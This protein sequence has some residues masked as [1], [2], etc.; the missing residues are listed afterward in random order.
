MRSPAKLL[1]S[2][3]LM[4]VVLGT[5]V[6]S[7]PPV[8]AAANPAV[9]AKR[10]AAVMEKI[11]DGLMVIQGAGEYPTLVQFRQDNNF[12]YLTGIDDTS[13]AI[14]VMDG[15][16]K[17]TLLFLPPFDAN[18]EKWFGHRMNPGKEAT[19][20]T[21]IT[22]SFSNKDFDGKIAELIGDSNRAV[23]I[24][25]SPME[26]GESERGVAAGVDKTELTTPWIKRISKQQAFANY[27]ESKKAEVKDLDPI[28]DD[29]R[30]IKGQEEIELVRE[31]SAIGSQGHIEA[32]KSVHAGMY[33]YEIAALAEYVFKR[34]G[35]IGPSYFPIAGSGPNSCALHYSLNNRKM[36]DGD[37]VVFDFA[38]DYG[39]Y[40]SDITR[41]FPVSGKFTDEQRKVYQVVLTAQKAG[42]AAVKP[43]A[44][45]A[46]VTKAARDVINAAG[47]GKYWAHGIGHY[48][49]M[50][51]HDVGSYD[52][53]FEPGVVLTV[54]PGIYIPEKELGV[55]I[56]D[57]VLVTK[58]GREV[59]SNA[60][61]EINDIEKLMS[62]GKAKK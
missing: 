37:I 53:P 56:E 24:S 12:Y 26:L 47:Y 19:E 58:E 57:V 42:I 1:C 2:I 15:K 46:D 21:G 49:G 39:Y 22:E 32:I 54:E 35:A 59:L 13:D 51:V 25:K 30:R 23:Y 34:S 10:R 62:A 17:R 44:T 5:I 7:K 29:M 11:G 28:L 33:E 14:L 20:R 9:Y 55:R 3:I 61:K 6:Q 48:V 50:G 43:C 52:K 60:P 8:P 40:A 18:Y 36:K 41:T 31:S 38:P 16:A 4:S 45:F 27:F